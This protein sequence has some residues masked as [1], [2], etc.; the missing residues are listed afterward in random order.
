MLNVFE[1]L[2]RSQALIFGFH[3]FVSVS[4]LEIRPAGP[5]AD[6]W[7]SG[8]TITGSQAAGSGSWT[9]T[10]WKS[11]IAMDQYADAETMVRLSRAQVL[12]PADFALQPLRAFRAP[13][14]R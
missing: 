2:L 11:R 7:G 3:A 5:A 13:D 9:A 4:G 1:T 6:V 10:S 14:I 8:L 12:G